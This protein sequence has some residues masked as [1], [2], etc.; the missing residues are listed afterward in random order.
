MYNVM[1]VDDEEEIRLAIEKKINWEELG[2]KVVG[3]AENGY[4]ALDMALERHPDVVLTDINMPFMNGLEFSKQLK[5]ELP[6]TKF[7]ILSG[8]DEFEYA[9]EAIEIAVVEYILKPVNSDELYQLFS[10][11]KV[12]LDDESEQRRNLEN[13]EKYYQETF[14][15]FK[16][17]NNYDLVEKAKVYIAEH[18]NEC[19]L[20]VDKLSSYLNV[21]PNYFST[22]FR[23]KTGLTFVSYLTNLRMEK[24]KWLLDNTDEK[25]Y[26]I[27]GLI[28]YDEPNYFSYV[29]KK[30]YGISPSKYRLKKEQ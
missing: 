20:S 11:L 2:F 24:A 12:R 1:L 9:K 5:A 19:D 18:Y 7:V 8:Y 14:L 29:F 13:L 4:E 22:L 3:T 10:R 30:A 21:T 23:K 17:I 16:D 15:Q 25:A 26:I 27:A 6:S 28:G